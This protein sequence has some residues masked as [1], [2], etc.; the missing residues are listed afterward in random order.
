MIELYNAIRYTVK[1]LISFRDKETERVW[2]RQRLRNLDE[3]TQRSALRKLL[4]LDAAE[5]LSDLMVPPGNRLEKLQRDRADMYS[6]RVNRQWRICFR[7]TTGGAE[8]V[9]LVDYH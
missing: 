9:E 5:A 1:V 3:I 4:I 8:D 2:N 7:W 6:I